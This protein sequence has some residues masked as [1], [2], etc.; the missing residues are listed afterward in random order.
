[1]AKKSSS[2]G[3]SQRQLRVGEVVRRSVN[4]MLIRGDLFDP[5]LENRSI[6]IT[7]A[8]PTPDLSG[9]ILYV[10]VLGGEN[11]DKVIEALDRNKKQIRKEAVSGLGLR[12]T[13]TLRFEIDRTFDIIDTTNRMFSD[14]K[15]RQDILDPD[16]ES[17]K[18]A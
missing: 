4:E 12:L 1:M 8:R 2:R 9:V 18:E 11:E 10:S 15:V 3:P 14:P 17:D 5:D 13:P 6:R 7:E 16:H